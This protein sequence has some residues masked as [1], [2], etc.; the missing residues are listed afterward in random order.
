MHN[1]YA[2]WMYGDLN[3]FAYKDPVRWSDWMRIDALPL[4]IAS[5][6]RPVYLKVKVDPR[7]LPNERL[8][9]LAEAIEETPIT[10]GQAAIRK[11]DELQNAMTKARRLPYPRRLPALEEAS[12]SPARPRFACCSGLRRNHPACTN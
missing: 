10:D 8:E 1:G 9:D 6:T 12:S 5:I 7:R 11:L 4:E 3:R 2:K